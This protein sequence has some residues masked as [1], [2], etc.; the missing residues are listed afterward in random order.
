MAEQSASSRL[1][2]AGFLVANGGD[3]IV[4]SSWTTSDPLL[5]AASAGID[6]ARTTVF[7]SGGQ[8]GPWYVVNTT[9]TVARDYLAHCVGGSPAN[10]GWGRRP[11]AWCLWRSWAMI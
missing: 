1:N 8:P 7:L 11:F 3:A 10:R 9:T 2:W 6:G 5:I 4:S